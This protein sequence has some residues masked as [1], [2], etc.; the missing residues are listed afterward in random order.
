MLCPSPP[1]AHGF[2]R[3]VAR[4]YGARVIIGASCALVLTLAVPAAANASSASR[5][6]PA[7]ASAAS[8]AATAR[9]TADV[10][11]FG[12]TTAQETDR[13]SCE[14]TDLMLDE[15]GDH[16]DGRQRARSSSH[17]GTLE[18]AL[19]LRR[20]SHAGKG[21]LTLDGLLRH[22]FLVHSVRRL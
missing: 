17:H 14:S 6:A 8:S 21:S 16:E 22:Q 15:T 5:P 11:P 7:I 2:T 1:C 4:P 9:D 13:T 12:T 10:D 18:H 3:D 20:P 19:G